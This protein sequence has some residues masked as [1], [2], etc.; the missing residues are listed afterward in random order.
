MLRIR[1]TSTA[2]DIR[3]EKRIV[4]RSQLNRAIWID[5]PALLRELEKPIVR[6]KK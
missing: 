3:A 1:A 5:K 6:D 4:V 2:R